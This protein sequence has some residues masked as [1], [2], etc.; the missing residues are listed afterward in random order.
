MKKCKLC[1]HAIDDHE[2][3]GMRCI[4]KPCKHCDCQG[5]KNDGEKE[6]GWKNCM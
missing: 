1:K 4:C 3:D 2:H 6:F 5:Y